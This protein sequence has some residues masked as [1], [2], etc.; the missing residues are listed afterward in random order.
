MILKKYIKKINKVHGAQRLQSLYLTS[1]RRTK[2]DTYPNKAVGWGKKRFL[3]EQ[4]I[5][6]LT[7]QVA[8][9]AK[10]SDGQALFQLSM[11]HQ[12]HI[13]SF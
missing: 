5:L 4:A 13:K 11:P 3:R 12:R 8:G 10:D 1:R 7:G 9:A 6:T 2:C